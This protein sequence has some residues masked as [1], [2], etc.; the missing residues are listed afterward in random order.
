MN[1]TNWARTVDN[2]GTI[3]LVGTAAATLGTGKY[4]ADNNFS[5]VSFDPT[6]GSNGD[7]KALTPLRDVTKP[8]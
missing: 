6:S 4:D 2:F 5:L 1:N 3:T 8:G 7:W